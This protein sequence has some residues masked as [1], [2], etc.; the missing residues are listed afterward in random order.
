MHEVDKPAAD[1]LI[2]TKQN[3]DAARDDVSR[4]AWVLRPFQDT[5]S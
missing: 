1:V 3:A 2:E 5:K 4:L